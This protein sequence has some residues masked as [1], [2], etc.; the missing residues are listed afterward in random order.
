[1]DYYMDKRFNYILWLS[2]LHEVE[3]PFR[4]C[5]KVSSQNVCLRY[6]FAM[7]SLHLPEYENFE[8]SC[9]FLNCEPY[10][11]ALMGFY[12][13]AIMRK[14][15]QNLTSVAKNILKYF[16]LE[17][18]ELYLKLDFKPASGKFWTAV[19]IQTVA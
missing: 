3:K 15:V 10:A 8:A 5:W 13:A 4:R 12:G 1:M 18:P 2:E 14:Y 19:S 9:Q 7:T 17:C 11:Y 6:L 16:G